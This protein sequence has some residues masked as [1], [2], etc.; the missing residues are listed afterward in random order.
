[1]SQRFS[2]CVA[3]LSAWCIPSADAP[4]PCAPSPF[5]PRSLTCAACGVQRGPRRRR[6][7]LRRRAGS[8][9]HWSSSSRTRSWGSRP[10]LGAAEASSPAARNSALVSGQRHRSASASSDDVVYLMMSSSSSHSTASSC[11]FTGC[12][13]NWPFAGTAIARAMVRKPRILLLDEGQARTLP[14]LLSGYF[15]RLCIVFPRWFSTC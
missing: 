8:P 13:T 4:L 2:S 6:P 15:L 1:M 10:W 7:R 3:A 12:L 11:T 5:R 14:C 9:T